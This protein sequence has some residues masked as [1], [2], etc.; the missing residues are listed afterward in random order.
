MRAYGAHRLAGMHRNN[1]TG[2]T[3][4][5]QDGS[6]DAGTQPVGSRE[7]APTIAGDAQRDQQDRSGDAA[8]RAQG[9]TAGQR[10]RSGDAAYGVS[11]RRYERQRSQGMHTG[12]NRIK[13]AMRHPE[14]KDTQQANTTKAAMRRTQYQIAGMDGNNHVCTAAS[15][16][17]GWLRCG[18]QSARMHSRPAGSKRRC[19]IH[20]A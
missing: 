6:S 10:N 17:A 4:A 18:I 16:L 5:K 7:W 8:Y 14:R 15:R 1:R 19:G 2:C 11:A 20:G 3:A 12:P 9:D 13:S